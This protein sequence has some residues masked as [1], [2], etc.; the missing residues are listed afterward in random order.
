[1]SAPVPHCSW[2][3]C[4]HV[5]TPTSACTTVNPLQPDKGH[6][7]GHRRN[8]PLDP[9]PHV[10]GTSA[11][12]TAWAIWL[13]AAVSFLGLPVLVLYLNRFQILPEERVLRA[14]F[15]ESADY[16]RRVRRW[17]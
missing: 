2:T 5:A 15:P 13:S 9:Q 10:S 7:P 12:L 4:G 11:D 3:A 17:V 16:M 1:M 14:K 6:R 8:L